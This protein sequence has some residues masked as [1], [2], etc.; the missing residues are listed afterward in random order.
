MGF[1]E[2]HLKQAYDSGLANSDPLK[3]FYEPVLQQATRYDRLTGYFSS[4]ILALAAKGIAGFLQNQGKMRLITSAD[5]SLEDFQ[6][7]ADS[8]S[9]TF[10]QVLN[11]KFEAAM[12]SANELNELLV[13]QH[14]EA[15]G[16][17]LKTG[18]LEIRVLI[19]SRSFG[20]RGIFHSKVGVL[21]DKNG[22]RISFSGSINETANGWANNVEEFKVF[23]EWEPS[24]KSL[25]EHDAQAFDRYWEP[26][27]ET[28]FVCLPLPK[29]SRDR[30]ISVAPSDLQ[31]LQLL[32][33]KPEREDIHASSEL[34]NYQIEAADAWV[35]NN[36]LGLLSMATGTGKTRTALE[37]IR[38]SFASVTTQVT[39]VSAPQRE[40]AMQ[41][42]ES[43]KPEGAL[44]VGGGL[45]WRD[46]LHEA[47][48]ELRIG[49][50][51]HV[52]VVGVQNSLA[53][54][55]FLDWLENIARVA[56]STLLVGDE[57]HGL[58]TAQYGKLLSEHFKR[59][60]G[61]SA[62]PSRWFDE[63]GTAALETYF[64]KV[65]YE[66]GISKALAWRDPKTGKAALSNYEY[67]PK[68]LDLDSEEMDD[69]RALSAKIA[70]LSAGVDSKN[71]PIL[72]N[73]NFKRA[74]ILKNAS[75]KLD[76]L[77]RLLQREQN[78]S[79]CLVY[80]NTTEQLVGASEVLS[81]LGITFRRFTGE[82]GSRPEHRFNGLSE[83]Q[84][85]MRDFE[86]GST[87]VL[88]AM[89]CLDE[90]VDIPSANTSF[91]LASNGNPR[92]FI[93]RRGRL[94]RVSPGKSKAVI[95]DLVVFPNPSA[96]S[97]QASRKLELKIASNEISRIN[98][99]SDEALNRAKV[100]GDVVDKLIEFKGA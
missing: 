55:D 82:E 7:L 16:W 36:Y 11:E 29:A 85:I 25:V 21:R 32:R 96:L 75:A 37:C 17:L 12:G 46:Q 30:L 89:K 78:L 47:R 33:H 38:R 1:R 62:T 20:K 77:R 59:R 51:K 83:R 73:L 52:I 76:E 53:G 49:K 79:G 98:E 14:L 84:W 5:F 45:A 69:Y 10:E 13:S 4:Q 22:E 99:F 65:V 93:Q 66:F 81:E 18:R 50:R 68:F 63:E 91:I 15:L 48:S 3:E 27:G 6:V 88:L 100:I 67:W 43:L 58:A 9:T 2:L 40:I 35:Q 71:D 44:L 74:S 34:R 92:E 54:S 95:Y 90:G 31:E 87:Q 42:F 61:L 80:C 19:P 72:K 86:S 57:V 60:L 97:D 8:R 23:R 70:R 39:V 64:D 94:L 28:Q 24:E 56:D 26:A 41:W